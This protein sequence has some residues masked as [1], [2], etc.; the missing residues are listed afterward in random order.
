MSAPE[1]FVEGPG[2]GSYP[3]QFSQTFAVWGDAE[4]DVAVVGT[5]A[6]GHGLL[7]AS[8]GEYPWGGDDWPLYTSWAGVV[9]FGHS[10]DGVVG[11]SDLS[12]GVRGLG[13]DIGVYGHNYNSQT[14]G[15][16]GSLCCA[17]DLYGPVWVHGPLYK[18]GGG[19]VIDDPG[20]PGARYLQH[21]FVESSE[22]KN[23]YDG[24]VTLDSDGSVE[25]Q[26]P[27]WFETLNTTFRY[28]LTAVGEPAPNLHI[29]QEVMNGRFT[30]SGG[31]PRMKV[32]WCVTGV[33]DDPWARA[34]PMKVEV[35]K[36]DGER[37]SYLTPSLYG[38]SEAESLEVARYPHPERRQELRM[39][40]PTSE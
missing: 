25:V 21:S 33:R 6:Y 8:V 27:D 35:D 40:R 34:N 23:I 1:H 13:G 16:L 15:Y 32:C 22:R 18:L 12:Y 9:G 5:T 10:S 19:F 36:P 4:K 11:L 7:G 39:R 2:S 17:A 3:G 26:L 37:G 20:E 28:Q 29:S 30:I 24:V 14:S 31:N 38:R